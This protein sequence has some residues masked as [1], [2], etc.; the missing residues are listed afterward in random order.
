MVLLRNDIEFLVS[1]DKFAPFITRPTLGMRIVV[2]SNF[3][4]ITKAI[5]TEL[6]SWQEE[7]GLRTLQLLRSCVLVIEDYAAQWNTMLLESL[8]L[9]RV[10]TRESKLSNAK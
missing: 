2:Q 10:F 3:S 9:V 8:C 5:T 7:I 4:R 6:S 1:T